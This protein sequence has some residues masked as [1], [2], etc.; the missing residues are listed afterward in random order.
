MVDIRW[1]LSYVIIAISMHNSSK[2]LDKNYGIQ[3]V[4]IGNVLKEGR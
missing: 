3:N 1:D 4:S 2:Y